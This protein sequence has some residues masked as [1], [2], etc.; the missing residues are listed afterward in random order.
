LA[1]FGATT[2]PE[3]ARRVAKDCLIM[4][5]PGVDIEAAGRLAEM[6]LSGATNSSAPVAYFQFTKGLAEYRL[7]R[8][9]SAAE[10][11]QKTL[12]ATRNPSWLEAQAF[13]ALA[14]AQHQLKHP[15]EAGAAL[16]KGVEVIDTKLPKLESGD[17]GYDWGDWI[18]AHVLMREAKALI[19]GDPRSA[20]E[21]K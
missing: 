13:L 4:P 21:I 2:D 5:S 3:V 12:N 15:A 16:A 19:E 20:A 17:L 11:Q 9:D 1:L 10:W 18:I 6:A 8:F 14:M 7:G